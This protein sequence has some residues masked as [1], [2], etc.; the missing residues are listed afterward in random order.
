[1]LLK[2]CS[3][4]LRRAKNVFIP[5]LWITPW[6]IFLFQNLT[7]GKMTAK[8]RTLLRKTKVHNRVHKLPHE[9]IS[10]GNLID[11]SPIT[12]FLH[13]ISQLQRLGLPNILSRISYKNSACTTHLTD[14]TTVIFKTG[15]TTKDTL[16]STQSFRTADYSVVPSVPCKCNTQL[17]FQP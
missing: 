7:E 8:F 4:G 14:L 9:T 5:S 2:C 17:P 1:M 15:A 3:L 6:R 13:R 12:H 11:P 16:T 10:W